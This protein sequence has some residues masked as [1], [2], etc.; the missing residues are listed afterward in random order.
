MMVRKIVLWSVFLW[1]VVSVSC[2]ARADETTKTIRVMFYNVENLFDTIDD[3]DKDDA[4]FL[5][6]GLKNWSESRFYK[7]LN[8]IAQVIITAGEGNIP[9]I[10]GLCEVENLYVLEK[11]VHFT[12]LGKLGYKIIHKES[13]DRRGIDVAL[14]YRD[15]KFKPLTYSAIPVINPSDKDFVTRDILYVKGIIERDTIHVY[16]NHWPSKYGGVSTSKPLR[17][18]AAR[19]LRSHADSI[20]SK[21]CLSKIIIMGDFNDTPYDESITKGLGVKPQTDAPF[22]NELYNMSLVLANKRIGSNKY[23]RKWDLIDQIIISGSLLIGPKLVTNEKKFRVFS[24]DFL[25]EK[26]KNH[27]GK[28]PFRTYTGMKYNNGFSD[29]LPVLI[30][31]EYKKN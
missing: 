26:D 3:P 2:S 17:M 24:R 7:K 22:C 9:S 23:Q 10:V 14:I 15:D 29:H 28:K 11:L 16:V 8:R 4:E 1:F 27:G 19:T 12:P 5:P 21:N 30:D 25:L 31:L 13:P 20:L 6:G 18:L